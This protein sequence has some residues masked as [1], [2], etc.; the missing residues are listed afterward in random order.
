MAESLRPY[1][2]D[3]VDSRE[4]VDGDRLDARLLGL[5][6][7]VQF[8]AERRVGEELAVSARAETNIAPFE[9]F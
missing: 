2:V 9:G 1:N 7:R 4:R 6:I 8:G 5:C 3:V